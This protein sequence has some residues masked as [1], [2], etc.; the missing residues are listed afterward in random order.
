MI[1]PANGKVGNTAR[2]GPA[3]PVRRFPLL[4]PWRQESS[5]QRG[6]FSSS[7]PSWPQ[8]RALHGPLL[9]R[10][11]LMERVQSLESRRLEVNLLTVSVTLGGS[12]TLP[13]LQFPPL[14]SRSNI[15]ALQHWGDEMRWRVFCQAKRPSLMISISYW[16][17][18][19]RIGKLLL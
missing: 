12:L 9:G 19:S 2:G 18:V 17:L 11:N 16:N 5:T 14:Q 7:H 10:H 1:K 15:C 4:T 8:P 6:L 3:S 13:E